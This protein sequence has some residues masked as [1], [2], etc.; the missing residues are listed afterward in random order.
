MSLAGE[1]DAAAVL[2]SPVRRRI[3]EVLTRVT[4]GH[5]H[6]QLSAAELA[7][8]L[9]LHVSTVRFHL[10]Q[11]VAVRLVEPHVRRQPGAGR[12]RKV[13]TSAPGS[14]AQLSRSGEVEALRLLSALLATTLADR[15]VDRTPAEAG[16]RR[17]H[18][19]LAR[20]PGAAPATTP[21]QWLGRIAP[22]VEVLQE[23]GYTPEVA[24]S[25]GGRT[26]R[27]TLAHCPFLELARDNPA[28]VCGIHR[29]L[30]A[31][32]LEQ[33]GEP[34]PEVSLVPFVDAT[35]CVAHITTRTTFRPAARKEPA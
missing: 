30:I 27:V 16:R 18:D 9:G 4:D 6:G 19:H 11:L 10:D 24:T 35:T 2:T 12:P 20:V 32:S 7:A 31:G 15:L 14:F 26:A 5:D 13:Y 1:R 29:G 25:R 3:V 22:M 33:L 17:A 21:G 28:V 8:E 23:W 34:E